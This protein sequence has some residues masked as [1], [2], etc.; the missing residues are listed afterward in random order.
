[1]TAVTLM[2]AD[3]GAAVIGVSHLVGPTMALNGF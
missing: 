2:R 1:M 3:D